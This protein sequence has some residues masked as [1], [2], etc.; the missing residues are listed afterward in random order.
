MEDDVRRV[1]PESQF[2]RALCLEQKRVARSRKCFVLMLLVVPT[3]IQN[4]GESNPLGRTAPV[5]LAS[6][7]ETDIVGWHKQRSTLGI[8]F[9]ELVMTDKQSVL[10]A[11]RAKVMSGI[12]SVL[13]ADEAAGIN[14]T[15]CCFPE[16]SKADEL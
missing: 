16:D 1:L 4:G 2:Q 8:I 12:R 14:F 7:R 3:P 6:V 5:I 10:T 9:A 15:L 11:L 13:G